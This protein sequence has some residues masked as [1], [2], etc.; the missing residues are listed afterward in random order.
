[1]DSCQ[2]LLIAVS[3]LT[4]AVPLMAQQPDTT[5]S[6]AAGEVPTTVVRTDSTAASPAADSSAHVGTSLFGVKLGGFAEASYVYANHPVGHTVVGRLYDRFPNTFTLNALKLWLDRP[7][8]ADKFDA[9]FHADVIFGQNAKVLQSAGFDLGDQGDVTQLY[10]TLNVPTPN[11]NGLQFKVGK[12]VTLMGLEVIE[13]YANPNWSE[14]NQ[15]VYVE[16]FTQLGVSA[17]YRFNKHV[18]AQLRVFN[19]WDQVEDLNT[20]QSFMGRVGIAPDD[21]TSIALLGYI[22]PEEA[23]NNSALRK[24]AEVLLS[25]KFG[26]STAWLQGDYGTEDAN[27]ALPDPTKDASW[28]AIGGWYAVD[29]HPALSLGLR[30]DYLDD[31]EGAR[32][33]GAFALESP[34]EQQ[35]WTGTVTLGVKSWA[36]LLLRPEIRYD[37]SNLEVFD[38]NKDQMTVALSTTFIF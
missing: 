32:T 23:D 33:A 7:Y 21:V 26:K 19:G 30:G 36:N 20:H 31:K 18:D 34:A 37:H 13:S 16:N 17:E 9:G 3:L 15:F 11:G 29:L 27:A 10:V 1:M 28:W 8:A 2:R 25:R 38:G 22:G 24:G 4:S 12:M 14:G 5:K 35:L 6:I